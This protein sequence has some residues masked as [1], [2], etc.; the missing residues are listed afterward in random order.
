LVDD[1]PGYDLATEG[2]A[3]GPIHAPPVHASPEPASVD[4]RARRYP[5]ARERRKLLPPTDPSLAAGLRGPALAGLLLQLQRSAGNTAVQR[6]IEA[7]VQPQGA[8]D[9][10]PKP[11]LDGTTV[12]VTNGGG[13]PTLSGNITATA[14]ADKSQVR[15][16]GPSASVT[17]TD[18]AIASGVTLGP[19]RSLLVGYV[20]DL[21]DSDRTFVYQKPTSTDPPIEQKNL[22]GLSLD[23]AASTYSTAA[24]AFA[25]GQAPFFLPPRTLSDV[26]TSDT[27]AAAEG[28]T[29]NLFDKPG[30]TVPAHLGQGFYAP[31]LIA[32][33]GQDR[34]LTSFAA[35]YAGESALFHMSSTHWEVPW[36]VTLDPATL[37]GVGGPGTIGP[38]IDV[39][40]KTDGEIAIHQSG[41]SWIAFP[42]LA[43][44]MSVDVR[45]LLANMVPA[46]ANDP[47]AFG[48]TAAALKAKNPAITVRL[49]VV[50]THGNIG[51]DHLF[52]TVRG[53]AGAVPRKEFRLNNGNSGEVTFNLNDVIDAAAAGAG[54]AISLE[55][56][57]DTVAGSDIDTVHSWSVP[58]ADLK[59][60]F[61]FGD[62]QYGL[63]GSV[64]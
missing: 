18:V 63:D 43:A 48:H 47:V 33:R 12:G 40:M 17:P 1:G 6:L 36:S 8:G 64:S 49:L 29:A 14:N 53:P 45:T 50:T 60:R 52:L 3:R 56:L 39:P 41:K 23:A 7:T 57:L 19:G 62:G 15:I 4:A 35:K 59:E 10:T 28:G 25:R 13:T 30:F 22:V 46:Q 21:L 61:P 44:A 58:L 11:P 2:H 37:G 51:R 24:A 42:S 31:A 26:H 34:F 16:D 20:Q 9:G 5:D 54:S 27:V 38:A 55:I 32:T